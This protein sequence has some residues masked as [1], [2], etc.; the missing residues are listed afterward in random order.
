[1][2]Y[3]RFAEMVI[4]EKTSLYPRARTEDWLMFFTH[5]P[6]AAASHLSQTPAGKFEASQVFATLKRYPI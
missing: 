1:M 5:D 2:G 4:D 3:D 6:D